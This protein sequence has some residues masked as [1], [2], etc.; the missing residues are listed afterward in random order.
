MEGGVKR[1]AKPRFRAATYFEG[2][3]N[4]CKKTEPAHQSHSLATTDQ[5]GLD[6]QGNFV[7]YDRPPCTTYESALGVGKKAWLVQLYGANLTDTRAQ[8]YA[9]Y[10]LNY[11]ATPARMFESQV[12]SE[13]SRIHCR[14]GHDTRPPDGRA[15][16][17]PDTSGGHVRHG[18]VPSLRSRICYS[19]PSASSSRVRFSVDNKALR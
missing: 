9:N 7:A 5:L 15:N 1:V 8:L 18:A 14:R 16:C 6:L 4:L 17:T 10:S 12:Q 3:T 2:S 11:T 13:D 19:R